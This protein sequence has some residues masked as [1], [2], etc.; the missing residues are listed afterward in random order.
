MEEFIESEN[1]EYL[2]GSVILCPDPEK[3]GDG[4]TSRPYVFILFI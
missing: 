1:N 3:E 4:L 2:I